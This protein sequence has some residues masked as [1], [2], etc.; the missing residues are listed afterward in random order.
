MSLFVHRWQQRR[1]TMWCP[2]AQ[3]CP[4]EPSPTV[5]LVSR[6]WPGSQLTS[7]KAWPTPSTWSERWAQ[8]MC[9]HFLVPSIESESLR[10]TIKLEGHTIVNKQWVPLQLQCP[11]WAFHHPCLYAEKSG[12]SLWSISLMPP[13]HH[14]ATHIDQDIGGLMDRRNINLHINHIYKNKSISK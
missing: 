8:Q 6:D 10:W 4:A 9:W 3:V 5:R 1:R 11:L 7:G 14:T 2:Q 12:L 13:H